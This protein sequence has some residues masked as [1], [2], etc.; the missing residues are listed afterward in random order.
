[1]PSEL[2]GDSVLEP[3]ILALLARERSDSYG[4]EDGS[5]KAL[6]AKR[7][8][9]AALALAATGAAP[10]LGAAAEAARHA[11]TPAVT[12]G[13]KRLVAWGLAA[14]VGV[15]SALFAAG[16]VTGGLIEAHYVETQQAAAPAVPPAK[17]APIPSPAPPPVTS[18]S[19]VDP[20]GAAVIPSVDI[21]ALPVAPP[22]VDPRAQAQAAPSSLPL[23]TGEPP[24]SPLVEEHR[25]L[26]TART[27]VE[28][29]AY[30]AAL[31]TLADHAARF[32]HGKQTEERE[33]LFVQALA[34]AGRN[35]EALARARA[36]ERDFPG[37]IYLPA[38]RAAS[39]TKEP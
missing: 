26:F 27:A 13:T 28:R 10:L 22:N 11:L 14:K 9:H 24:A 39:S 31:T 32:P 37:S 2:P 30:S 5:R 12:A 16:G 1:M 21:A 23:P 3:E 20:P 17:I 29:G 34:G 19:G 15:A 25:L 38:V 8:E 33:L 7:L 6:M 35:A 18:V 4:D 36:F